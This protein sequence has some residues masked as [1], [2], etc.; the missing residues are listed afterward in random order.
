M[1]YVQ[2]V[3]V[4][5]K[6]TAELCWNVYGMILFL[7]L[8]KEYCDWDNSAMLVVMRLFLA[9][10]IMKVFM[11]LILAIAFCIYLGY[12]Y[13]KK[14]NRQSASRRVIKSLVRIKYSVLGGTQVGV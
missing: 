4:V 10:A 12:K 11:M 3:C 5:L 9:I 14:R 7:S 2:S 1:I 6:E 8:R 13:Y